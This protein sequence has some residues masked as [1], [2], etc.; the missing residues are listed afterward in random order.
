MRDTPQAIRT[1]SGSSTI[2]GLGDYDKGRVQLNVTAAGGTTP[3][4]DVTVLDTIDGVNFNPLVSF[5]TETG[6]TRDALLV[7]NFVGELVR[8][9]WVITGAA[10]TFTFA[11]DGAFEKAHG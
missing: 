2:G 10:A 9:S 1:T 11:V 4:L 5:A 6:V 3:T 7:T 8:V